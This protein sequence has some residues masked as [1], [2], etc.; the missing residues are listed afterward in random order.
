[1]LDVQAWDWLQQ[2]LDRMLDE[3]TA[4]ATHRLSPK[5]FEV[6]FVGATVEYL[7]IDAKT[8]Q[9]FQVAV[10]AALDEIDGA[11]AD[12]L[13]GS[14]MREPGLDETAALRD[15]R[16]RWEAYGEAQRHA[17]RHPLAVLEARPRHELLREKML[18][19]LLRLNYGMAAAAR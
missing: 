11:R 10:N 4:H 17:A 19:W 7:E 2:D 3:I 12:M 8:T 14:Q 9:S 6:K 18:K 5:A 16:A 15:S 13:R 1:V